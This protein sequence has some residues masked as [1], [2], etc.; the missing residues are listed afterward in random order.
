MISHGFITRY[1]SKSVFVIVCINAKRSN[2]PDQWNSFKRQRNKVIGLI[3]NAKQI[4]YRQLSEK[5][6]SPGSISSKEWWKLCKY[7]YTGRDNDHSIPQLTTDNNIIFKDT[8]KARAFNDYFNS[9]SQVTDA[10]AA[11]DEPMRNK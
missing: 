11:I 10:N 4:Y 3:H 8:D 6:G 9:I 7:L 5:M 2:S 1:E